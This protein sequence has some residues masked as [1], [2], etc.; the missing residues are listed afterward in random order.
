MKQVISNYA[1]FTEEF[2]LLGKIVIGAVTGFVIAGCIA[3]A[4]GLIIQGAPAVIGY[5]G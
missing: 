2:N 5:A 1:N 4:I 3:L